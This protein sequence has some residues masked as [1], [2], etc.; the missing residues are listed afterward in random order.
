MWN[1]SSRWRTWAQ[2]SSHIRL[3][4]FQNL[5]MLLWTLFNPWQPSS[6]TPALS[7]LIS[8]RS[9][10]CY[11]SSWKCFWWFSALSFSSDVPACCLVLS[12]FS[13]TIICLLR[14]V[15]RPDPKR[16]QRWEE[17]S[18]TRRPGQSAGS[19]G[20]KTLRDFVTQW[21]K[22]TVSNVFLWIL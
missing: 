20:P 15:V 6:F 19:C 3:F 14:W 8:V 13:D 9:I 7:N 10:C 11:M 4:M 2:Y 18:L 12:N 1:Q 22:S 21:E 16:R 5:S 17:V